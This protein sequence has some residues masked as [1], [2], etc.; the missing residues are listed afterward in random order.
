M[1]VLVVG[2]GGNLGGRVVKACLTRNHEVTVLVRSRERFQQALPDCADKVTIVEGSATSVDDLK[3]AMAGQDVAVNTAGATAV[4]QKFKGGNKGATL[5]EIVKAVVD[6]A[7]EAMPG[8]RLWILAGWVVM[9]M[10]GTDGKPMKN[11]IKFFPDHYEN[12]EYLKEKGESLDWSILCPGGMFPGKE[13][14][15][16]QHS[17][18]V[19]PNWTSSCVPLVGGPGYL[20]IAGNASKYNLSTEDAAAFIADHLGPGE[21]LSKKRIGIC[22][23]EGVK[24]QLDK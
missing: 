10:P 13:L 4:E 15:G 18:D 5:T 7:R 9:D 2:A 12:W 21:E 3:K 1:K 16:L 24:A 11:W 23:P 20:S 14:G 22:Y 6:A 19:P 17:V 8:K